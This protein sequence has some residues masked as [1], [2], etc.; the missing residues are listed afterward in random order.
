[1][2]VI[3]W[4]CRTSPGVTWHFGFPKTRLFLW[5]SRPNYKN[6][7]QN[8]GKMSNDTLVNPL[9]PNCGIWIHCPVN[10]PPSQRMWHIIWMAPFS[11]NIHVTKNGVDINVFDIIKISEQMIWFLPILGV[12]IVA[13]PPSA[14][15]SFSGSPISISAFPSFWKRE[16]PPIRE[17]RIS[18][19][20]ALNLVQLEKCYLKFKMGVWVKI[21]S[22]TYRISNY[23]HFRLKYFYMFHLRNSLSLYYNMKNK[24]KIKKEKYSNKKLYTLL[25][26]RRKGERKKEM[27]RK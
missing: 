3:W 25:K 23:I 4:H 2:C 27:Q 7:V 19:R 22:I 14:I 6:R 11:I 20:F 9:P 26:T 16:N 1:M 21:V 13:M 15:S 8:F 12:E 17:G 10:L 24:Y 18:V 5:K